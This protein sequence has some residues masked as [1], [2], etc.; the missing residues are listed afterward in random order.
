MEDYETAGGDFKGRRQV[1][2]PRL[3]PEYIY[4]FAGL[5]NSY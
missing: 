1:Y 5:F 2:I 4:G 3:P